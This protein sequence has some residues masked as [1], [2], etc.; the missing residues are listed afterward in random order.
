MYN[1]KTYGNKFGKLLVLE[2]S[3]IKNGCYYYL[4]EHDNGN[5]IVINGRDLKSNY[6]IKNCRPYNN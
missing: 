4:C 3:H 6:I 1:I 2:F 5:K